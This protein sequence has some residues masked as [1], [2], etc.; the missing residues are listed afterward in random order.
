VKQT[1]ISESGDF[2]D[3]HINIAQ[4]NFYYE[5]RTPTHA[6]FQKEH[7]MKKLIVGFDGFVDI[8]VRPVKE[9]GD[10]TQYFD[11]IGN[12]GRYITGQEG[13]SC[14]IEMDISIRKHGGNAPLL[15]T[16]ASR[17]GMD[18]TC[19]GMMG[20]PTLDPVFEHLPFEKISYMPP[21]ESTALE[22]NDGKVFFAP[23]ISA[24]DPWGKVTEAMQGKI[25]FNDAD[26]IALVNWSEISFA[27]ELWQNVLDALTEKKDRHV[28]FDLCDTTRKPTED[29]DEILELMGA[30]TAKASVTLSLNENECLD[31]G[32][33]IF[34][35]HDA[36]QIAKLLQ[37]KYGITEVIVHA[38][39]WSYMLAQDAEVFA[40]TI[41]VEKPAIST[42][43]GDNFNGSYIV[44]RSQGLDPQQC[45]AF[46]HRFV[47]DYISGK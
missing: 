31:I 12:F 33:K 45:I 44:A 25:S 24:T 36:K 30:F 34:D 6:K 21:G 22:F 23:G 3:Y 15:S 10:T 38:T 9:K 47:H 28:L 7:F 2:P 13:K 8:M 35:N 46:C 29:V 42:G 1:P 27:K 16:A 11:T 5:D 20:Y 41:Y 43:A 4:G 37:D 32:R 17:L 18:V 14:S 40:N 19:I 26:A 39:K